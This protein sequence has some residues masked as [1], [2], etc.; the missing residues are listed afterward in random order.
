MQMVGFKQGSHRDH[1]LA[2]CLPNPPGRSGS[3]ADVL[4]AKAW[5]HNNLLID[6]QCLM[7]YMRLH[8]VDAFQVV[9]AHPTLVLFAASLFNLGDRLLHR[10]FRVIMDRLQG[11]IWREGQGECVCAIWNVCGGVSTPRGE[12]QGLDGKR[13]A[14]RGNVIAILARKEGAP[15][16]DAIA[17]RAGLLFW[18]DRVTSES[19][20]GNGGTLPEL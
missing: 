12:L 18:L 8:G 20:A 3:L 5:E 17:F 11:C 16:E 13:K 1:Y 7:K 4:R 6:A 10:A 9:T 2:H 14:G 19:V 15:S